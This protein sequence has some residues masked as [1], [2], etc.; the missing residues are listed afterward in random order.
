MLS[1][2]AISLYY[3]KIRS[4]ISSQVSFKWFNEIQNT[5]KTVQGNYIISYLK[6]KAWIYDII[7]QNSTVN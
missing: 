3:V 2:T 1:I 7:Q 4:P 5:L 6:L